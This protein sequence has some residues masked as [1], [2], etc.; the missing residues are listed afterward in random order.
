[1]KRYFPSLQNQQFDLLVCGGGIYGAWTAYDAALRGLKVA[2]VEQGDWACTTSSASSKLVHGGL[3]YLESYDFKLVKKSLIERQMLLQIAPHRVWPLRFGVP[4]YTN[5][6]VGKFQLKLG[7]T[8]Y[9]WFAG[10]LSR[11][12]QHRHFNRKQFTERFPI[13]DETTLRSG[14]SYADAQTDDARLV[15]ELISGAMDAHATCINYCKVTRL[16]KT[17]GDVYAVEIQDQ[18][19]HIKQQIHTKQIVYTTGQWISSVEQG[20]KA[21]T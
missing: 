5:S 17:N 4:V 21:Y 2:I 18:V 19:N 12:M 14:F 16:L 6:R 20:C 13:L 10:K 1:M 15:L 3:R 11:A 8:L 9:D 7:L